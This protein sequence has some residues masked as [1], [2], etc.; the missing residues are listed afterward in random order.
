MLSR[1]ELSEAVYQHFHHVLAL[2]ELD[3]CR[4]PDEAVQVCL[5]DS[6]VNVDPVEHVSWKVSQDVLGHLDVD[7]AVLPIDL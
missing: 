4:P 6:E 3:V 5:L 2:E 7:L 1:E